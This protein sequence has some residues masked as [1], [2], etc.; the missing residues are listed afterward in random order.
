M[1]LIV[2]LIGTVQQSVGSQVSL[3]QVKVGSDFAVTSLGHYPGL[4]NAILAISIKML[5]S[6]LVKS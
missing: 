1:P 4:K 3:N 6:E 2:F 5:S